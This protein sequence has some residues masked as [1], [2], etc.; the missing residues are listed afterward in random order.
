MSGHCSKG[1]S[2]FFNHDTST[3]PCR[4]YHLE[5]QCKAGEECRFSHG[6]IPEG[7]L[8][9]F[10]K[11]NL[12]LLTNMYRSMRLE[13]EPVRQ[14][15]SQVLKQFVESKLAGFTDINKQTPTMPQLG[16]LPQNMPAAYSNYPSPPPTDATQYWQHMPHPNAMW[17][18]QQYSSMPPMMNGH[19]QFGYGIQQPHPYS[20]GGPFPNN[21]YQRGGY[22]S[23]MH[24]P[25]IPSTVPLSMSH[26]II[27][28]NYPMGI[29][30]R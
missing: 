24:A 23:P 30:Q 26:N 10:L 7:E 25:Q 14:R 12:D 20:Y 5:K 18:R 29:P 13:N 6:P 2:C 21:A 16:K 15:L 1:S 8:E 11:D 27:N 17:N 22:P 19:P 3:Y 9:D 4:F 28:R